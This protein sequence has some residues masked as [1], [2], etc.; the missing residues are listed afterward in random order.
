MIQNV[1]TRARR[2]IPESLSCLQPQLEV[3]LHA[4]GGGV[5]RR[6]GGR[7]GGLRAPCPVERLIDRAGAAVQGCW[8][9]VATGPP[10]GGAR[11]AFFSL[12]GGATIQIY[13]KI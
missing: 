3:G 4:G 8:R 6:L 10:R 9:R 13:I 7:G 1:C 5:R 2:P 12:L 11:M